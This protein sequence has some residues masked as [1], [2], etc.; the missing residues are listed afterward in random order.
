[1][2]EGKKSFVLYADLISTVEKMPNEKAGELFKHVL[3]YVNDLDPETDDLLVQIAFEPIKNQLKRDLEKWEALKVK[4][5]E[6]GKRSA[7]ARK[8]KKQQIQ[9]VLTSVEFAQQ[10][11]TNSTVNVNDNVNVNVNVSS[12]EDLFNKKIELEN[13]LLNSHTFQEQAFRQ[14]T[15]LGINTDLQELI[16]LIPVFC[17]KLEIENDLNKTIAQQRGHFVNWVKVELRNKS[18]NGKKQTAREK[19]AT[20]YGQTF[21]DIKN[22]DWSDVV[23]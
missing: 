14:L 19:T 8:N 18:K 12:K 20:S 16:N 21:N 22:A 5:S 6:A 4:R 10:S 1:M 13:E 7:E 3:R 9:Q 11:S 2:A 23:N 17:E 15:A